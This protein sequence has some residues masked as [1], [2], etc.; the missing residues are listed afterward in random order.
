VRTQHK[1]GETIAQQAVVETILDKH[2][3]ATASRRFN[4][5]LATASINNAMNITNYSKAKQKLT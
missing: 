3:A 4:A 1:P 2:N 5:T